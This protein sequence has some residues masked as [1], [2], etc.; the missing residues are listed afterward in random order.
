M[1]KKYL[2]RHAD[3]AGIPWSQN[4]ATQKGFLEVYFSSI[5]LLVPFPCFF[6]MARF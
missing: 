5:N 6:E 3:N 2:I 4:I 1:S